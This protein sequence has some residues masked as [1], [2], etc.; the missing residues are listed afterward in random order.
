MRS[1]SMRLNHFFFIWKSHR[2]CFHP[3]KLRKIYSNHETCTTLIVYSNTGEWEGAREREDLIHASWQSLFFFS[4]GFRSTPVVVFLWFRNWCERV[5][6]H[7]NGSIGWVNKIKQ[8]KL[9]SEAKRIEKHR[10]ESLFPFSPLFSRFL[11]HFLSFPLFL[12]IFLSHF[13][14]F[15]SHIL[16]TVYSIF[17]CWLLLHTMKLP[18]DKPRHW[19]WLTIHD[20]F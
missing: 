14:C 17:D 8:M 19:I 18:H 11:S 7:E 1:I 4:S 3:V 9:W 16:C 2:N 15:L 6:V 12:S 13:A 10:S 20:Q 5:R